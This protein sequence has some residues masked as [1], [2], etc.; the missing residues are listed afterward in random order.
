MPMPKS[1]PKPLK[2]DDGERKELQE[3]VNRHKMPQQIALRA[4]IVLLADEE[5]NHQKI[6]VKP[7]FRR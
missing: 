3:L 1:A 5:L 2:L 4:S 7:T 6:S